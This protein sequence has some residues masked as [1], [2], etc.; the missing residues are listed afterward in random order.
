MAKLKA[1]VTTQMT[2]EHLNRLKQIC[3]V[4]L[5]GWLVRDGWILNEEEAVEAFRDAEILVVGYDPVT[6]AVMDACPGLKLI[7]C[8]RG[9]PVNIDRAAANA[10]GIP[11][12]N[13]PGRNANAVAELLLGSVIGLIRWIPLSFSQVR[14]GRYLAP[15]SDDIYRVP[16]RDDIVWG[17]SMNQED[18]P[19]KTYE[20]YELFHRTFGMIGY[21][22]VGRR[23]AKFL[24]AMDMRVVIYDPYLPP[25]V[26]EA[27]GVKMLSLDDLLRTSDF[28]SLH[29]KV[30]EETKNMFG[31]REFSLMKPTAVFINTARGIIVQQR[32]L[33]EAL[34]QKKIGGAVLDVFWQEPLPANHPLLKMDNVVFTPHIAGSSTDVTTHH[35]IMIVED[36][37]R[38]INGK[39]LQ[40]VFNR[41]IYQ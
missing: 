23:L 35:S 36:V 5:S 37:E 38:F 17:L 33:I 9:N 8:T 22:A 31:A 40:H 12:I 1:V 24:K 14:G 19:F 11:I 6:K 18:N 29:C 41:E 16:A 3:D 7:A 26:A 20:G 21:G 39:S 4:T 32:A 2:D 27:E 30:T 28:V 25:S 13:T 34:E 15:P 10:R